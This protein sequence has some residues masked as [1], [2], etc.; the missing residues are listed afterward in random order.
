MLGTIAREGRQ[1]VDVRLD[2]LCCQR[3][4]A[5][6]AVLQFS[7]GKDSTA[8]MYLAR[9]W[10]DRITVIFAETGAT[11]P[12]L[13]RHIEETC[14]RLGANLV[15]IRPPIDVYQHTRDHGLP[16]DVV[17]VEASAAMLPF[18]K[19][20]PAQ[21]LQPYTQ[22]CGA[23][24]WA[25]MLRYT[26]ENA[27]DLVLR[28]SK[29]S[30]RRVGVGPSVE[31]EGIRYES[32]LWD[33]SDDDV[34][35]YLAEQGAALPE[36]YGISQEA[37]AREASAREDGRQRP[38]ARKRPGAIND[39]LDCWLCT[40]H[41]AHHGDEKMR[42]IRETYPELWPT[43]AERVTRMQAVLAG[44]MARISPAIDVVMAPADKFTQS[45]QA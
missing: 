35:A 9:P 36:H 34:Y 43:V 13:V 2:G 18:L 41:L 42:Y 26:R 8:L 32:P 1:G 16:A 30:D 20:P 7:G 23:M 29:A 39:S 12:H 22:C 33:W 14:E 25:P 27:V 37:T 5:K 19:P 31:V 4:D 6:N 15:I 40:A 45:A 24:L 44:E 28:G 3:P 21:L 17:P 10:L 38:D 11:F